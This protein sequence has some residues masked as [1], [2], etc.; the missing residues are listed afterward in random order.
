MSPHGS[1]SVSQ[2]QW[3]NAACSSIVPAAL[4]LATACSTGNPLLSTEA[5]QAETEAASVATC[6]SQDIAWS[7]EQASND[8]TACAGRW[9]FTQYATEARPDPRCG[10]STVCQEFH[11]TWVWKASPGLIAI[12]Y[13]LQYATEGCEEAWRAYA[14]QLSAQA[15]IRRVRFPSGRTPQVVPLSPHS[16]FYSRSV[17][18]PSCVK[19]R[20]NEKPLC[21]MVAQF[22]GAR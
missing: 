9:R 3:S 2:L 10:D 21:T 20:A 12:N 7:E 6:T 14:D 5:Q 19:F 13:P 4:V 11:S 15:D 18:P 8:D 1:R 22:S 16:T 17:P